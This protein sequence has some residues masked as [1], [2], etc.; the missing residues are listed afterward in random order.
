MPR[1]NFE[2]A[3]PQSIEAEKSVLGSILLSHAA[4]EL[5]VETLK[6]EDFH[7]PVHQDIFAV[8]LNLYNN[9]NAVDSVTVTD[10]LRRAGLL[11]SVGGADY[12]SEL[13]LFT[14]T[15]ANVSHYVKIVEE[16][17][18]MRRLVLAGNEIS[19]DALEGE[20][21]ADALLD[22]A[23]RKIFNISMKKSQDSL[24]HIED[25]VME[26]YHRIGELIKLKGKLTGLTTGFYELDELTTGL[27]K[28]DLVIVA[29][30]PSMGKSA[31]MLNM[32]LPAANKG[33]TVCIFSLEMSREQLVMRMLCS[34]ANVD[35]QNVKT[36]RL[37]DAELLRISNTLDPLTKANIYIDDT[38]GIGVTE[39]RSKCRRLKSSRGLD[40]V[41]I[42]YLQLMQTRG[43][44]ENRVTEIAE[45]TRSL[46]ILA[47]ELDV[48]IV[49]GSQLSRGPEN[50]TDH[51][52]HMADLR[53]SG[54]IEQ[55]A[56][57]VMML[58]RPAVYDETADNTAEIILSKNRNGPTGT[59]KLAWIDKFGK[60][61]N[62]ADRQE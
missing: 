37:N 62:K 11:E 19:K 23:E 29:G 38:G 35:M 8:M 22:D 5:A 59:A 45:V 32:A 27:Q 18:I 47:R 52:P 12:V 48:P 13:S 42:D 3:L 40:M 30:R 21:S 51:R 54:S 36:G 9:G 7:L 15:A 56:D 58:Y 44:S 6:S 26:S 16:R 17:S 50:R 31:F 46:K 43:K 4:M 14:P 1:P 25:T 61:V 20:S 60:F 55:D 49:L 2:N 39:I 28:S 10:A 34:E 24:I 53:E 41:V 33:A 57:M